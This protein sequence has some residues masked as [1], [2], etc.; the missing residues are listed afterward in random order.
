MTAS[1]EWDI[2]WTVVGSNLTNSVQRR[3]VLIAPVAK[4]HP[5]DLIKVEILAWQDGDLIQN[6]YLSLSGDR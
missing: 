1:Q 6:P 4:L 5:L 2:T 3:L